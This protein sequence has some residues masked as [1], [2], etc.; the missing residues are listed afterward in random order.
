MEVWNCIPNVTG[1]VYVLLC[2]K[3]EYYFLHCLFPEG[4][5]A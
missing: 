5:C 3:V 4:D 1:F 2:A